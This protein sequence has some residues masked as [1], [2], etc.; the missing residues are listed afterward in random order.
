MGSSLKRDFLQKKSSLLFG[1]VQK[2]SIVGVPTLKKILS[3]FAGWYI[4]F[5][6]L[7]KDFKNIK[8]IK[9]GGCPLTHKFCLACLLNFAE[10]ASWA[11]L[12]RWGGLSDQKIKKGI[13]VRVEKLSFWESPVKIRDV[14]GT[15][16]NYEVVESISFFWWM[17]CM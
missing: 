10:Q 11:E 15:L 3:D 8:F 9:V 4:F 12:V 16:M 2:T 6:I 14:V 13:F 17:W 1:N 7:R 5:A